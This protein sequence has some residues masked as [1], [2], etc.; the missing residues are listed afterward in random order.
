MDYNPATLGLGW[1][2]SF[3]DH[4]DEEVDYVSYSLLGLVQW[5]GFS[6]WEISGNHKETGFL[7]LS[8]KVLTLY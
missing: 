2:I 1:R 7:I 8:H 3:W 4:L 6:K 5:C